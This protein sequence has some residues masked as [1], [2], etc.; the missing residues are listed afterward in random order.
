M[1]E[2]DIDHYL[3]NFINYLALVKSTALFVL[4]VVPK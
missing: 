2:Y 3:I 4:T 1:H